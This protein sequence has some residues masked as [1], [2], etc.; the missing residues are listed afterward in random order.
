[1]NAPGLLLL[2]AQAVGGGREIENAR[3]LTVR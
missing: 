3:Q 1:M 2:V